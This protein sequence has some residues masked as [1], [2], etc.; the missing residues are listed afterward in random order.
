MIAG[1][2]K[3]RLKFYKRIKVRTSSGSVVENCEFYKTLSAEISYKTSREKEINQQLTAINIIKAKI[4]FRT[5]LDETMYFEFWGGKYDI[6]Y[7]EHNKRI[8]TFIT[9]ERGKL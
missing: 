4:R 2:Q 1:G 9:A 6:R 7:I 8:D 5:D 3:E